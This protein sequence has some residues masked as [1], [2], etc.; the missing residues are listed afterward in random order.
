[1]YRIPPNPNIVEG[2]LYE[3]PIKIYEG[4][5]SSCPLLGDMY[6]IPPNPNIKVDI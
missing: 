5:Q 2:G 1:M 6:R 4:R 3:Y